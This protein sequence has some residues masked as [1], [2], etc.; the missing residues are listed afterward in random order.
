QRYCVRCHGADKTEG[1]IDFAKIHSE[2]DLSAND[3]IW[4]SAVSLID[5]GIMPPADELKTS[6]EEKKMITTWYQQRFIDSVAPHPGYFRPRR[7]S[8]HEYR[9]TLQSVFGF[10]LEVAIIEA[11]QTVA[12]KSLVMKLLP[13]DPPG[14]SGFKNDTSGNPLTTVVWDQYSYLVDFA[15]H[16][17]FSPGQHHHLE[18]I[19]GDI[20]GMLSRP[21]SKTL[22]R[23]MARRAYRRPV[24]DD[25]IA[26]SITSI[27]EA[28]TED[29]DRTTRTELKTI[30]MSPRFFYR[31]LMMQAPREQVVDVDAFEF[32]ER[33]SYFLWADMP[34]EEL[35]QVAD[36]GKLEDPIIFEQQID[37]MLASPKSR[38]LAENLGVEWFSLDQI[39]SVSDNPPVADA[40]KSQPIDYLT[41]LF[42]QDRPIVELIDSRTAFVNA[43]TAKYYPDDRKQ[44]AATKK[45]DGVEIASLPNQMISLKENLYRGGFLTIPGVLAMNRG[46]VLR[47]TWMLERVLGETLPDP[48]A[49]VGQVPANRN[50][51]QLSF[52]QRFEIHR[53]N[54]TC[55]VC[56]DKI[57]PLG[58]ALQHFDDSGAHQLLEQPSRNKRK[59]KEKA[60]ETN[61]DASGRLPSGETFQDFQELKQI[62]MT[63]QKDAVTEN[64]VRRFLGYALCR[65]LE[66]HDRQAV[67][68]IMANLR[69]SDGTFR[70]LILEVCNSLPMR[71]T[72]VR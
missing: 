70:D 71:R 46:P 62:L 41:Y 33:L 44:L 14:R 21:Q 8:A 18:K 55:A 22:L 9:N 30:L 72:V 50:G 45:Q 40:L 64:V 34:D 42:T 48:P 28:S 65:K 4:E 5:D 49:N 59:E 24:A 52:R 19:V 23:T 16:K 10:P 25:V 17:L 27:D 11:E 66:Y 36:S 47:G 51:E 26:L 69:E 57:D 68:Q 60:V 31:G 53:S 7:L 38:S 35:I 2:H 12:E 58:F 29:L 67:Q 61:I 32:A 54:R 37:R 15:I 63:G 56:H 3:E 39:D 6:A 1:E 13:K 43:H 20:N